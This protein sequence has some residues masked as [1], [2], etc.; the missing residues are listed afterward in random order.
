[1]ATG[2]FGNGASGAC[3]NVTFCGDLCETTVQS[4]LVSVVVSVLGT[5]GSFADVV[6]VGMMVLGSMVAVASVLVRIVASSFKAVTRLGTIVAKMGAA[7]GLWMA[8]WR[9]SAAAVITSAAVAMG[10]PY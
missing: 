2:V 3:T 9:S 6:E 8:A 1:M 5:L 10:I 7:F 4:L